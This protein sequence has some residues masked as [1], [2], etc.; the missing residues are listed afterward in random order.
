MRALLPVPPNPPAGGGGAVREGPG[1]RRRFPELQHASSIVSGCFTS[2][3]SDPPRVR[4]AVALPA[5]NS[6]PGAG[7]GAG[8]MACAH[9]LRTYQPSW[10]SPQPP[11]RPSGMVPVPLMPG[12]DASEGAKE[13]SPDRDSSPRAAGEE[14]RSDAQVLVGASPKSEQLNKESQ[15]KLIRRLH[16]E[17]R[18]RQ[19]EAAKALR[20]RFAPKAPPTRKLTRKE[21]S[22]I[23]ERSVERVQRRAEEQRR[24]AAVRSY[25]P[26][27]ARRPCPPGPPRQV[28]LRPDELQEH[29]DRIAQIP[30]RDALYERHG[31]TSKGPSTTP[32]LDGDGI[33]AMTT[34]LHAKGVQDSISA[35]QRAT[36]RY[37]IPTLTV[38]KPRDEIGAL[39]DYLHTGA[40]FEDRPKT[41]K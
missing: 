31:V 19:L 1:M 17:A 18:E 5:E 16:T 28:K 33:E 21:N 40:G 29:L 38:R 8:K 11:W 30:T 3:D 37:M 4:A 39:V 2:G 6:D 14:G 23:Y 22:R 27:S 34:R 12:F 13:D 20:A 26:T 41:G 24:A 25:K 32:R 7:V 35:V 36:D 10:K 9:V 15:E